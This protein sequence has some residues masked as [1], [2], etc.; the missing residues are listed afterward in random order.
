[1]VLVLNM[2]SSLYMLI[3]LKTLYCIQ[4][5]LIGNVAC[6]MGLLVALIAIT[7]NQSSQFCLKVRLNSLMIVLFL[8]FSL[9]HLGRLRNPRL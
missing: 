7:K 8:I 4:I 5:S 6:R 1:M 9:S 3:F 2:I